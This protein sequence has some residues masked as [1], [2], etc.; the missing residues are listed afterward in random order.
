MDIVTTDLKPE[1]PYVA[2]GQLFVPGAAPIPLSARRFMSD[3]VASVVP[4][5]RVVY[6]T[7]LVNG[8]AAAQAQ[9]R[10]DVILPVIRVLDPQSGEDH[11]LAND[12]WAFD[13]SSDGAIAYVQG[14][15][16]THPYFS[17]VHGPTHGPSHSRCATGGVGTR[18]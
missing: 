2:D 15:G 13:V 4:D 10:N 12:A 16:Q 14:P 5:G 7:Y 11:V 18:D 6:Q 1:G 17:R 8:S 9:G 3:H